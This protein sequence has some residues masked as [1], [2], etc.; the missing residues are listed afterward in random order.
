M[1]S[2]FCSY[3]MGDSISRT[4]VILTQ[5]K[6][7][8]TNKKY[9]YKVR[10]RTSYHAYLTHYETIS[11]VKLGPMGCHAVG[12]GRGGDTRGVNAVLINVMTGHPSL[13][14]DVR[15]GLRYQRSGAGSCACA[16]G[17]LIRVA[18]TLAS[19]TLPVPSA[20]CPCDFIYL[21]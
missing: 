20:K 4:T 10:I 1:L 16:A 9:D 14:A 21:N 8:D 7:H 12:S 11:K 18:A 2:T 5:Y 3:P 6:K 19:Y 13:E 15:N 17:D